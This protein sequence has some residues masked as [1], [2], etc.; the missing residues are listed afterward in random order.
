MSTNMPISGPFACPRCGAP[1]YAS[2]GH[3]QY[4]C[5]C[6]LGTYGPPPIVMD[7]YVVRQI[8]REELDKRLAVGKS[9]E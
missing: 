4:S 9:G 5:T 8:V 7:E 2:F 1:G 3:S 6:R